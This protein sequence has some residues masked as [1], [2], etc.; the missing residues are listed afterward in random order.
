MQKYT[1]MMTLKFSFFACISN[2]KKTINC[3]KII[4][5]GIFI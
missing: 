2:K 3:C 4:F 1:M 5:F